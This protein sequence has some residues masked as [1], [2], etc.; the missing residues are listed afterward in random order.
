[1]LSPLVESR[2][3]GQSHTALVV[4]EDLGG[5]DISALAIELCKELSKPGSFA[6][7]A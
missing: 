7:G 1:M 2:A 3:F 5:L 6:G 4:A